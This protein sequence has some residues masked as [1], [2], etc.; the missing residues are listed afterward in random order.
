MLNHKYASYESGK[1]RAV[2][3]SAKDCAIFIAAV[4]PIDEGIW[5]CNITSKKCEG[6]YH[7]GYKRIQVKTF[8]RDELLNATFFEYE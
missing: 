5:H 1:I 7:V 4:K 6:N 8:Y 3:G 2:D